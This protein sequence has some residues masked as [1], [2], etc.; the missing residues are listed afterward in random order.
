VLLSV[1]T[2]EVGAEERMG[3]I[4]DILTAPAPPSPGLSTD[5]VD[6]IGNMLEVYKT[7]YPKSNFAPYLD[8]IRRVKVDANQ[9][10]RGAVRTE[11]VAFFKMLATRAHGINEV[12][13]DELTNFAQ[14]VT[15]MEEY[16]ISV[17]RSG[18]SQYGT[19]TTASGTIQ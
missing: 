16:R 17:P 15:P 3:R 11:M 13:A 19:E 9:G 8:T 6:Q 2:G 10:D 5:W 12:A 1:L 14:M 18:A 4:P 7:N